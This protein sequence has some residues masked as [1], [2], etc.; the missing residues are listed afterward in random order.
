MPIVKVKGMQDLV[1]QLDK[2]AKVGDKHV[3][4]ALNK[5]GEKVKKTEIEVAERVHNKYSQK[6]GVKE[7]KK[8]PI[9]VGKRGGK[10]INIGIRTNVTASQR[11]KDEA[12]KKAGKSRATHWDRVKGLFYNNY[13]FHHNRSGTYIAGSDWLG[14][15]Y[16][17]S[18]EEAFREM[19]ETLEE[20]MGL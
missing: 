16:E 9:K 5:A 13:G 4:K 10:F 18:V 3:N 7:I 2:M 1:D 8:Y 19:K 20:G 6:V 11:R 17:E 15:A 12:N 14:Q